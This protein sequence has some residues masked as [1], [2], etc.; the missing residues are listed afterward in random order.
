MEA[1]G[2]GRR[3]AAWPQC[4]TK[5]SADRA[6]LRFPLWSEPIQYARHVSTEIDS[7]EAKLQRLQQLREEARHAGSEKAVARQREQGKLLARERAEKLLDEGSFV[8]LDRY[9]RH[10]EAEF[11]MRERRPYG[12]AVVTGYGTV[13]GR[14]VFVFSQ[15]FTVFGGS[16]SEV[17]AEKI[18]KVM[19][20]A[21]KYGCP[22]IG[23]ND[24]G[25][26]RIQ[27]GVVS[28]AGY[29]EIFWRNV[30]A[31]GVVPQISLVMGPCAGGAVYSPAITDF[32]FM[33]EGS[34][35]MFITGP[36][37]VK[38]VTGEEVSFEELGGA[39]AHATKSGVAHFVSATEE[40]CLEDARYLLSF[41]PQNNREQV[42]HTV[43]TD[44]RERE[45]A[46]LDTLIPDSPNKPYDM[47]DVIRRVI[48]DG[49]FLEVQEQ[50]AQ[51]IVC[52]FARLGGHA[53][54]VVGNQPRSL[55]G[56]LDIDASNKAARFVRTC[57]AFNIPL[58][59][60]VDVPGFLP[61]TAQEWG[62]IIRHGA[63]LLY[64]YCEATVPKLTVITRKAYG[65][66]YDVMSSKHI[67]ADF[68]FAW[69]TA[70]VAVMGPDGAVNIIYRHRPEEERPELIA[71]YKEKFANPYSAAERGYVDD[72]IEPR[73]TRPVLIDA[74][75]TAL[76]K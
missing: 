57:D 17:F 28:L 75:E 60:F 9:V 45:D 15:D 1:A 32:I 76:T 22:V 65:G 74:L 34:S 5:P 27:E 52:G 64:A 50:F 36:D 54:G 11:G 68:N 33:V 4:L 24:S 10:R 2:V 20:M 49:E 70:E 39:Q 72:V 30:Q 8:E 37:V 44:P 55:A 69:P 31:S 3:N 12:D 23:I 58:V 56:V 51:N 61:G 38:T 59:T 62:G 48:D 16:L 35:Y 13:F 63:K 7:T 6:A 73:R 21:L 19:D 67:R 18:C 53:V 41:L 71:D 40:A 42:P 43:S 46:E 14:K 66:A 26:A 25:G 47:H 29:A